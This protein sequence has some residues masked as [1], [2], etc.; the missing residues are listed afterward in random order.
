MLTRKKK[1]NIDSSKF[2]C[3]KHN[4]GIL[5]T[6][7]FTKENQFNDEAL[8][9]SLFEQQLNQLNNLDGQR[10]G[11]T[12]QQISTHQKHA[13]SPNQFSLSQSSS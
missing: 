10:L 2:M 13:S 12:A 6:A 5:L 1:S 8:K 3:Q 7:G 9:P 11:K 4:R